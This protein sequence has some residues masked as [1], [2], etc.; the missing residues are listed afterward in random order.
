MPDEKDEKIEK[1]AKAVR[2]LGEY[3]FNENIGFIYLLNEDGFTA[4]IAIDALMNQPADN[5]KAGKRKKRKR[6]YV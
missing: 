5:A 2:E 3:L 4:G 6:I 1:A